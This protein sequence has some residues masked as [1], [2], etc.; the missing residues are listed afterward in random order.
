[1]AMLVKQLKAFVVTVVLID[2]LNG[3]TLMGETF[4]NF[5]NFGLFSKVNLTKNWKISPRLKFDVLL[6]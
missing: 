5:V 6:Y 3:S 4:T 1:M 2:P